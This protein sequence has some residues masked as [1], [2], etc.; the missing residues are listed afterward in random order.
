MAHVQSLES[1]L[2]A[3]M[4]EMLTVVSANF[5]LDGRHPFFDRR[6][7]EFCLSLPG[8]QK[9]ADGWNRVVMRRAMEGLLPD[10]IRWRRSKQNLTAN[11]NLRLFEDRGR[12]EDVV[13]DEHGPMSEYVDMPRLRDSYRRFC[14]DPLRRSADAFA[15]FIPAVLALWLRDSPFS[16]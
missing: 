16:P 14:E 5:G 12:L 3:F 6:L 7:I 1:P 2:L 13:L 9:L 11:F 15:V 8:D 10:E 4:A